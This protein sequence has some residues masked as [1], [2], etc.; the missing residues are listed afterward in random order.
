MAGFD[1]DAFFTEMMGWTAADLDVHKAMDEKMG[2]WPWGTLHYCNSWL[3]STQ[4]GMLADWYSDSDED[5]D[6]PD[7]GET[8]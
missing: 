2:T 3:K 5:E 8:S 7:D 4:R 6:E 1:Y